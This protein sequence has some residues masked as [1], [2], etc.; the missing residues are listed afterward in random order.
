MFT[1]TLLTIF[2]TALLATHAPAQN[3][4]TPAKPKTAGKKSGGKT[5]AQLIAAYT[6]KVKAALGARWAAELAPHLGEF[7]IGNL[8]VT[9]KLN[10]DG[11]VEEFEVTANTSNRP[12]AKFCEQFVRETKFEKPPGSVLAEGLLEIPFIFSIL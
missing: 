2:I 9:F 11:K 1:R 4:E 12:F 5:P 7:A 6:L 8:S 10:A 3:D